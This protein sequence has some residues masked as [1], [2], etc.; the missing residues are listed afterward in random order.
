MS[1]RL[2]SFADLRR[3]TDPSGGQQKGRT[4][5]G[6]G[7]EVNQMNTIVQA[8]A[9]GNGSGATVVPFSSDSENRKLGI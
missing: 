5:E 3:L 9:A 4:P 7:H 1:D 8:R 6:C 2:K